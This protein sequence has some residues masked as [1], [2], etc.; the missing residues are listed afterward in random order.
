MSTLLYALGRWSYRHPWRVLVAWLLLLAIAGGG[1][2]IFMKG[3]DNS[4]S[5]PGTESQAGI[6]QLGR[7]FPQASG[8]SAQI[9][10]VADDGDDVDDEPYS[11]AIEDS[12]ATIEDLDGVLA[13]TDPFDEMVTGLVSDDGAAAIIRLQFD[14][15]ATD[16]SPETKTALK[17]AGVDLE[18]SLPAGSQVVVGG[19]LFSQSLPTI[20]IIEAVGVLVALFVLIVTFRS[21]AMA[22]FPLASALIGVGLAVSL[23]FFATAFATISSTT[24]LLAVMLGLAVGIDY[25]LFIAARHQDQVRAGVEP[26]ESAARATGTAGS[27]VVF[28]GVTVLIALIGLSFANIPFLTTMGIAASIAVA[29]AV[30]V[31]L[32]LT[33]AFLGFAKARVVGWKRR[34]RGLAVSRSR[35]SSSA[36][37]SRSSSP[38]ASRSSSATASRSLSERSETK[39]VESTLDTESDGHGSLE[40]TPTRRDA[41]QAR[42]GFA[43]RWVSGVTRHPIITTIAVIVGLGIL[44]IPAASLRLALPNAGMQ[45]TTSEARQ[46]YDLTS[47]H[48]GPGFNGP[49]IMTGTIVTST[50]PVGLMKD[51]ATEIEKIPGVKTVA[52]ATPNETADTGIIQIVPETAPDDPA[53]A[54]LVRELR[55]QHDRLLDEY[56]VDLKVTGFTAVAID[57]SDRLGGALIPFGVFVVGLSLI[58]L[59]MVFRSIWVPIKAALGYLLSVAAAFGVVAAVFEWGWLAEP[60]NV[61][62]VGPII[63][64][65]PIILMGVLFG[66]AMDY[67]VFLVSR[68][69]EDFVHARARRG[70]SDHA[71]GVQTVRSGFKASARVVTAAAVIMFAVFAAFVPEGD[72]SLKP[73]A[74]GL[75]VGILIDAFLVRMTLVPAVMALLGDKAWWMP[76]W[77]DR[78][79]PRFDIEGEAVERE[80]ALA[81]WPEP[82]TTAAVV[83]EDLTLA[84]GDLVLYS[85]ASARIERGE[86]LIV[87]SADPRAARALL[88]TVAGRVAPSGGRLRVAGHLIPERSAWVRSHVGVAL[89]SGADDPV[90]ELRRAVRGGPAIVVVDNADTLASTAVRDRAAAVLRDADSPTVLVSALDPDVARALLLEARRPVPAVLDLSASSV[91]TEVLS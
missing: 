87:T 59:T 24:P 41:T 10:V 51:L 4:F 48:F 89:L 82:H 73:I 84:D 79:L 40:E 65:M 69:R 23:I 14:G 53:T 64:F 22:W 43:D 9:V 32:T 46:A 68:M 42:R 36:G 52:L 45:P 3:T 49:L 58:L 83:A 5:I 15:Q 66:L 75:A 2:A 34:P 12:I 47:E 86:S 76:A 72:A 57:I 85:G 60:L 21:F 26:E 20:S 27:A 80:L 91:P 74:L 67:E 6:Q 19:D 13:V 16:V 61:D 63:S 38:T 25:A 33:P 31:A 70:G 7:S 29:I 88:L 55:A 54:A 78:V 81:D 8:T 71:L 77:L 56:G 37:K 62:K 39:R 18:D 17:D 30:L 1:A 35:R 90:T 11:S 28:A 44:A 50:D